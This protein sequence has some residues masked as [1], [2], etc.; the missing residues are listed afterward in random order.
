LFLPHADLSH[1][2][3][4]P[5]VPSGGRHAS[6]RGWERPPVASEAQSSPVPPK[7]YSQAASKLPAQSSQYWFSIYALGKLSSIL[8]APPLSQ[9]S[10][11]ADEMAFQK[12]H[13]G[14]EGMQILCLSVS[15]Y[16]IDLQFA[17]H[18]KIF[19]RLSN[20]TASSRKL[21]SITS[22]RRWPRK[23]FESRITTSR[24]PIS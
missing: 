7:T 20:S 24:F 3:Q 15:P 14:A 1:I 10:P 11:T 23:G 9:P 16:L 18:T 21:P 19:G 17:C 6:G 5:S 12:K 8:V 13:E 22:W 2:L 4:R